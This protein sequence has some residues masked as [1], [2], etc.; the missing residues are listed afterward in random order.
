MQRPKTRSG[1]TEDVYK[2]VNAIRR[3]VGMPDLPLGLSAVE[4]RERIRRERRVELAFEEKRFWDVRRWK[5]LGETDRLTT[6]MAWTKVADNEYTNQ[7][8][9]V[10]TRN[11]WED[12]Y[13]I[14]PIPV[15]ELSRLPQ[16]E[17]NPGW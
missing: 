12:K 4:M 5:I 7:R 6:G 16:F 3:R 11:S 2:A 10:A 17:Q 14:F 9:V 15:L 13:L 1:P 8:I